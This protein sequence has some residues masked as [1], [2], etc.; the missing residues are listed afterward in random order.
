MDKHNLEKGVEL[1]EK[2]GGL[3]RVTARI[4]EYTTQCVK[5]K[6]R[7]SADRPYCDINVG[8]SDRRVTMKLNEAEARALNVFLISM[9]D[10]YQKQFESL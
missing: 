6:H 10:E 5:V 7:G 8:D 1:D 9:K 3:E 2:I 4:L